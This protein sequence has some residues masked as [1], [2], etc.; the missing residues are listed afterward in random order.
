[1]VEWEKGSQLLDLQAA[2]ENE[3][4]VFITVTLQAVFI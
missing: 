4:T 1:M 2:A 3:G